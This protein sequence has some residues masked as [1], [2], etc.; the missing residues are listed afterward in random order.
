MNL[1]EPE[2]MFIN[3]RDIII[4][5]FAFTFIISTL[6]G[7]NLQNLGFENK[8]KVL[9]LP[10][11][12]VIESEIDPQTYILGPGDKIGTQHYYQC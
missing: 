3:I 9:R 4:Q 2:S 6:V 12:F 1:Q 10:E 5:L 8:D 7:Q 11:T